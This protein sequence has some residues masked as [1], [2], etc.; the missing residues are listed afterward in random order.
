[1]AI[2]QKF[3]SGLQYGWSVIYWGSIHLFIYF[4]QAVFKQGISN[5]NLQIK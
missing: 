4:K 1:M 5:I 3:A 2:A